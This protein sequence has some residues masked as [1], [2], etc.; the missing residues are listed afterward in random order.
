[1]NEPQENKRIDDLFARKLGNTSLPPSAD[2]FERLQARMGHTKPEA[3]VVFWRNPEMQRY[4]AIAACLLL[5]CLFSWLYQSA[6]DGT[7][8]VGD[9]AQVAANGGL[10]P[11]K[12]KTDQQATK[13]AEKEGTPAEN[14][15]NMPV[16]EL[17]ENQ[18]ANTGKPVRHTDVKTNP[19][20]YVEPTTNGEGQLT[21]V[22]ANEQPVVAQ[23]SPAET[24][25]KPSP[26]VETPAISQQSAPQ[27]LAENTAKPASIAE[28]GLV[29]TIEEP[30]A[31]VAARQMT[32]TVAE[33]KQTAVA[34]ATPVEKE[35]KA[36]VLWQQVKKL[37]QGEVF[38]R[39]D[40]SANNERG[41]LSR[42][43]TSL[44]NNFEK[45]DKARNDE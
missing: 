27:R 12:N 29:V 18:L 4:M 25:A 15:V 19:R 9:G 28:R 6:P 37:K 44:K 24:P 7:N 32:K 1:M 30:A 40:N 31:L 23:T 39:R 17:P 14:Q 45:D 2:A 10:R 41:L 36:G 22:Q 33:D 20:T 42:A 13:P 11:S 16:H 21:P 26:T 38:A 35:T 8:G 5:V 3:K 34:V 43:F